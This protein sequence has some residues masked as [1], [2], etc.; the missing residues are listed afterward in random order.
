M[1][2]AGTLNKRVEIWAKSP[3]K[4]AWGQPLPEAWEVYA[5]LWANIRHPN[6]SESIKADAPVSKVQ[7]SIRIR[8]RQDITG[9]MQVRYRGTVYDIK[10]PLPDLERQEFVD[11]VCEA[12]S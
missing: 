9:G 5:R 2:R 10:A 7:A 1:L 4:D 6:G 12:V 11:L 8:F 3:G